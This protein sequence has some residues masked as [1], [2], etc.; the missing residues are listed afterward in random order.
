MGTIVN[1][2]TVLVCGLLGMLVKK[3][4]SKRI[5]EALTGAMAICVIYI[6][7]SGMLEA[8]PVNEG[9]IISDGLIKVLVMVI[10]MA[11][12][13]IIGELVD[14]DK[15]VN[16]LGELL[17]NKFVRDGEKGRFTQGFV[18]C[19]LLFCVGAMTING[20]FQDALG[21]PDIL[22]T[23]SVIDG[24][25][26]FVMASTLGIGCAAS[27]VFVLVYQGILTGLG[28][29]IKDFLPMASISYMS[30][31]GSLVIILIGTNMLGA[32]KVKTANMTP[33]LF[34]PAIIAPL[35]IDVISTFSG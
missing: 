26:C 2:L 21:K 22:I 23:K 33:S 13:T 24:V 10:S 12:G 18:S 14:I 5:S 34:L 9:L 32:T 30:V 16:H 3:G 11:L 7:V 35:L 31:T 8:P 1:F 6:G 17:E 25:M 4:V 27:S 19:S 28:L 15:W 29:L 20:A